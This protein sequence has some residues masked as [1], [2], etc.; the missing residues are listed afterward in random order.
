MDIGGARS[1]AESFGGALG[2]AEAIGVTLAVMCLVVGVF[3]AV[4]VVLAPLGFSSSWG[5]PP[6][7][8]AQRGAPTRRLLSTEWAT[9]L[10][11]Q[12]VL[13]PGYETLPATFQEACAPARKRR[14]LRAQGAVEETFV[15]SLRRGS[16]KG[17]EPRKRLPSLT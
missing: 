6:V 14:C 12:E 3:L 13:G 11:A 7:L 5:L 4:A 9:V 16:A 8:S 10:G 17:A 15:A 1:A 2:G